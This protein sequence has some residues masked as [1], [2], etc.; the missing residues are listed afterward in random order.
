MSCI[1]ERREGQS[2]IDVVTKGI[3][4]ETPPKKY[5][6][7]K[8]EE[9]EV[10]TF[11]TV[12]LTFNGQKAIALVMHN[13]T[14]YEKLDRMEDKYLQMYVASV[15]HDIRTPL[16]GIIGMLDM[17]EMLC[18]CK[19]TTLYS[20]V[21]RM[22]CKQLM[23]LTYDITDYS[24]IE[25]KKIKLNN[26]RSCVPEIVEEC[27]QLLS[28][29]CE[30]KKL[31]LL[32]DVA[33]TIPPV[34]SIDKNRYM[35][36]LLNYMG[37]ALKFTFKGGVKI[38]LEYDKNADLLVTSVQDSGIGIKEEDLS[39]L[40]KMFGKLDHP[41]FAINPQGVG[42]GLCICKK[43]A[44]AMGG[45]VDVSSVYGVGSTFIFSI[46]GNYQSIPEAHPISSDS[47]ILHEISEG[48]DS[49]VVQNIKG[50]I[51]CNGHYKLPIRTAEEEKK[52]RN[53]R[54][55]STKQLCE[56]KKILHVDDNECNKFVLSSY[57]S[58]F[59][60]KADEVTLDQ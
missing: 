45:S 28:F 30:K 17:L 27:I 3:K 14:S 25:A 7:K 26:N 6:H 52:G 32:K 41:D 51:L 60:M 22:S 55:A 18:H 11:Q 16:N 43:L 13:E 58:L 19:E 20:K 54:Q 24:Q 9:E 34:L 31:A 59:G 56:C 50:H 1:K 53:V 12:K 2:L 8:G 4:T 35:Q 5:F 10:F 21:A 47:I 49:N 36:I 39:K 23:F 33:P 29:H 42:F 37:N 46:R 48:M 40:F 38:K 44:E 15:V 57:L